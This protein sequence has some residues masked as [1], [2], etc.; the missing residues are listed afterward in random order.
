[1]ALNYTTPNMQLVLPVPTQQTGPNWSY[2]LNASLTTIDVHDHTT[3]KGV[4]I[5]TTGILINADLPINGFNLTVIRTSR[6]SIQSAALTS[7]SD[8]ACSYAVGT[9]GDLYW[10]DNVGNQIRITQSGAVSGAAGT[11]T[12]LPNGTASAAYTAGQGTFVFQQATGVAGNI[13]VGSAVLRYPGTY[14]TP[15]G[16]NWISLQVPASI[17]SGYSLT[18]PSLPSFKSLLTL[19]TLGNISTGPTSAPFVDSFVAIGTSGTITAQR[20]TSVVASA[21]SGSITIP[22]GGAG[23]N[24]LNVAYVAS[25]TRPIQIAF[26]SDGSGN[27]ASIQVTIGATATA[28][29]YRGLTLIATWVIIGSTSG[30][31]IPTSAFNT[32]DL[33]PPLGGNTYILNIA[34]ASGSTT[35]EYTQ[36]VAY[37]I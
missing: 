14:P 34:S 30:M 9:A 6:Y 26:I 27:P 18:L 21:T 29:I 11:I 10:N 28:T 16:T 19:D 4:Q 35:F 13:D 36:M 7:P 24:L 32:L 23:S 33:T 1:M 37:E 5:P 22:N 12:G 15:S 31:V 25:G 17:S 3:G 8:L 20:A 2:N